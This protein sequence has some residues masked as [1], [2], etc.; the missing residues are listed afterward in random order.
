LSQL[1]EIPHLCRRGIQSQSIPSTAE[2]TIIPSTNIAAVAFRHLTC[3]I[4]EPV[5]TITFNPVLCA[6]VGISL[7]EC[8]ALL[9]GH[10]TITKGITREHAGTNRV[11]VTASVSVAGDCWIRLYGLR[12]TALE[13]AQPVGTATDLGGVAGA[14]HGAV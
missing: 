2:L 13:D 8:R 1:L 12:V 14:C 4:G 9:N 10:C 3:R 7:T 6:K 5:A 11:R